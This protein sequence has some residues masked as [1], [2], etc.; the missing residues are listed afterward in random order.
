MSNMIEEID[1][2]FA[3]SNTVDCTSF[4]HEGKVYTVSTCQLS[5]SPILLFTSF[6]TMLGDSMMSNE[7]DTE[8]D[9]ETMLFIDGESGGFYPF[10]DLPGNEL[11]GIY[12]RYETEEEAKTGHQQFVDRVKVVLLTK[13]K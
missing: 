1:P 12:Q 10:G 13:S 4:T 7:D 3:E 8:K 2:E 6:M 5:G 9:Y 11:Q